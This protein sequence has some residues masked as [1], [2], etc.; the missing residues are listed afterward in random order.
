[1]RRETSF[2]F[3]VSRGFLKP[4][5]IL[6]MLF[7]ALQVNLYSEES[8]ANPGE[9]PG[10]ES[11]WDYEASRYAAGNMT[12]SMTLGVIFPVV[13]AGEGLSN[14]DQ[15]IGL[16]TVGG[17][18]TL[19]FNFFIS[20]HIFV[21]AELSGM[22]NS[23]RG[24]NTLFIVP[25]GLRIGYQFIIGRFEFPIS[26][27]AGA[28]QQIYTDKRYFGFILKPGASIFW[29]F[30]PDWSF[31]LNSVWYFVPQWR[32]KDDYE[33]KVNGNFVELTLSARYHF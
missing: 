8:D 20:P 17:S 18:G 24:G 11:G 33:Q 23:T 30:N 7:L 31:G 9:I 19:A 16:S 13:F 14:E 29:R 26:L 27:M 2:P 15:K 28:A 32:P 1:M 3:S 10:D 21:G 4:W 12:F 22:F 5:A 25:F 6:L